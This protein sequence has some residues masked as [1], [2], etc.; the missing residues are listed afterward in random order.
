LLFADDRFVTEWMSIAVYDVRGSHFSRQSCMTVERSSGRLLGTSADFFG[1]NDPKP[2]LKAMLKR[3][4]GLDIEDMS[5]AADPRFCMESRG[6][7]VYYNL[8][9]GNPIDGTTL[10]YAEL[11]PILRPELA[12]YGGKAP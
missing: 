6:L 3:I 8:P 11:A 9:T 4:T 2:L 10:P 12:G 7:S 5:G 1:K